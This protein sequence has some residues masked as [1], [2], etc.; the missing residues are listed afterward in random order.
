MPRDDSNRREHGDCDWGFHFLPLRQR[1]AR[2]GDG[3]TCFAE[4]GSISLLSEVWPDCGG[5]DG[6][7]SC[8]APNR[9]SRLGLVGLGRRGSDMGYGFCIA[10]VC[11]WREVNPPMDRWVI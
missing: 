7:F 10:A 6:F 3:Q 4:G 5:C 1:R 8:G 11:I 2:V 9:N